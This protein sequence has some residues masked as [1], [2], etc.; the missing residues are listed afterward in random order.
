MKK[1]I[2]LFSALCLALGTPAVYDSLPAV[3]FTAQAQTSK[4]TGTVVDENG[5]PMIGV[6]VVVKGA[7]NGVTT[8]IDGNFTIQA[9]PGST[10]VFSYVGY[11]SKEAK[12]TGAPI[13]VKLEPS[14]EVLSD[15]VVVGYGTQRREHLTGAVSS[16]DVAKT[17]EG[18]QIADVGRGL[19]GTTPGLNV[20]LPNGEIGSDPTIRIRGQVASLNGSANPLILLDNVEIPSI[21]MVNPD[22]IES[23]SV[24]KDAAAASIYGSKAAFGVILIQTKKGAKTDR[25]D[26]SYSGNFAWQRISKDMEMATIDGSQ[27]RLDELNR[28]GGTVSGAFW[29]VTA[30][31]VARQREWLEKY[32]G[33]I[34]V[35]DPFVYGRDWFVNSDGRKIF[36]RPYDPYDYM[37]RDWAPSMTH[38]VSVN[39]KS[40]KTS[41]NIGLGYLDQNG[42]IKPSKVDDYRRYNAS[43]NITTELN[44]WITLRAG[45]KYSYRNK[46]YGYS[47][48]STTADPWLYLYRW[49]AYAPHGYDENGHLMQ[50]PSTEMKLANTANK[51]DDYLSVNAGFTLNLTDNWHV[52]LDYTYASEDQ[53]WNKPG[54][55]FFMATTWYSPVARNDASGN[56]V[57][58]NHAGEV[59]SASDP[60]AQRAYDLNYYQYTSDGAG[61]DHIRRESTHAKRHTLNVTMDYNWDINENNNLKAMI[62]LNR[63]DWE[64]KQHW[65]QITNLTDIA[66]PSFDKTRGTQTASGN[67]YWDGQLGLFARVN[68][69]LFDKYLLEANIRY[70]GSSKFPDGMKWRAFPSVSGGWRIDQ[71]SFMK[72]AQPALSNAKIRASWGRIG[73]QSVSSSLYIPTMS[74]GFGSWIDGA[75]KATYVGAPSAVY[76]EVTWQD[77]ETTNVGLDARFF[78]NE[79][80]VS[81]DWYQRNTKNMLI[82][83]EGVPYTFGTSAPTGNF[84]DLRTRGWELALDYNH[85]FNKDLS[86]NATFTLSDA[87]STITRYG[88][89]RVNSGWYEGKEY[90]EIWGYEFDRLYTKDDFVYNADGTPVQV[91]AYQGKIVPEGTSGAKLMN[92]LSD[93]NG[94]YQDYFQ[95]SNTVLFGPGDIKYKDINGDGEFYVGDRSMIEWNGVYYTKTKNEEEWKKAEAA[96]LAGDKNAR[97]VPAGTVEN[98]GDQKKIGNSTPRFEYGIRLGVNFKGFDF[99][100][101]GQGI[102]KRKIWGQGFLALPGFNTG[103]GAMPQA[104]AGDYWTEDRTDAYYPRPYNLGG[105]NSGGLFQVTDHYLLNMAYFRIK[106]ITLGYTLPYNLTKKVMINKCRFYVAAENFFT[107]DKLRGLPIDPEVVSG[108]SMWNSSNYNSGRTGVGTPAMKNINFGIQLNF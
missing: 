59:C 15:V 75:A 74:Q 53:H 21:Q 8:D 28:R 76:P 16:I 102:G 40:G 55:K 83:M 90:G 48:N 9:N 13:S 33:K 68:Y 32:D 94:V 22:D 39:G 77:I 85:A 97:R 87:K 29:Y 42:L 93:P 56:P 70:D 69:A 88:T 37:I 60:E 18:R 73:D 7:K 49:D 45:L 31:G 84:G 63:T 61:I 51:E 65:S 14:T 19:Q 92:K 81:F 52:N 107:F 20:V 12:F 27:Y 4:A 64:S 57:Y 62:G 78:N 98:P 104:I 86:I 24:L 67:D 105:G 103:D 17:L 89:T 82:P 95:P 58:V 46:R 25:V 2:A 106:N 26:V 3:G 41:F 1:Q 43:A 30:E 34:G 11:A 35:D 96:L 79:F 101:F 50:S 6:S 38:N 54:T 44:K 100:I 71:E 47:T 91:W 108:V 5:E 66:N 10:L 23:I 99:S 80:G 36:I 72:W